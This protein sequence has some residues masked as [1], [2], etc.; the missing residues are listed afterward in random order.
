MC[1]EKIL[2]S[3]VFLLIV[4][5]FVAIINSTKIYELKIDLKDCE[6]SLKRL[7]HELNTI[8]REVEKKWK[9]F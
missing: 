2:V 5:S 1:S 6:V 9:D 7:K 4:L 8:K 3:I